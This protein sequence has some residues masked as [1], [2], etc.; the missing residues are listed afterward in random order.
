M[1]FRFNEDDDFLER[2]IS[3]EG[4]ISDE[5]WFVNPQTGEE[6]CVRRE[7]ITSYTNAGFPEIV[8]R[9]F[10][11]QCCYGDIITNPR[12]LAFCASPSCQQPVCR[13]HS[14]TCLC[15]H[16]FCL[17]CASARHVSCESDGARS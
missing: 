6:Y 10:P 1:S 15:G 5:I 4:R 17:R 13:V 16:I 7:E 9:E 11:I 8:S 3:S 2:F 12:D 14:V